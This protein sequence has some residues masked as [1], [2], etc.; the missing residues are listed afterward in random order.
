MKA[1]GLGVKIENS[2]LSS[3]PANWNF[4]NKKRDVPLI[5]D[6]FVN[7]VQADNNYYS[8]GMHC[9]GLPDVICF[10]NQVEYQQASQLIRT[11][12]LYNIIEKPDLNDNETFSI[13]H[14]TPHYLLRHTGCNHFDKDHLFYNPNGIWELIRK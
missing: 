13:S 11:F 14:Q 3:T 5:F 6:T 12:C 2:G 1:G 10:R 4:V 8:C 9:F 7:L